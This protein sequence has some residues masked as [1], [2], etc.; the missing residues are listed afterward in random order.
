MSNKNLLKAK[1]IIASVMSAIILLQTNIANASNLINAATPQQPYVNAIADLDK[2]DEAFLR[3]NEGDIHQNSLKAE[4]DASLKKINSSQEKRTLASLKKQG[5]AKYGAM[6]PMYVKAAG[7]KQI[8][9]LENKL[10][11]FLGEYLKEPRILPY[12]QFK[13]AYVQMLHSYAKENSKNSGYENAVPFKTAEDK[14]VNDLLNAFPPEEAYKEYKKDAQEEINWRKKNQ[15]KIEDAAYTV[16]RAAV[17]AIGPE[18]ISLGTAQ[19]LLNLE[20]NGKK[21]ITQSERNSVYAYNLAFLQKQNFKTLSQNGISNAKE[22]KVASVLIK[23]ITESIVIAGYLA[24]K[25]SGPYSKTV[26]DLIIRS[27][28]SIAFSHILGAGFSALLANGNYSALDSLLARYT[29]ME[30]NGPH[31]SDWLSVNHYSQMTQNATGKYLG[32]ISEQAQYN[33]DYSYGNTFADIAQLLSEDASA[34]SSQLLAKYAT[35]RD[36][37]NTIKPFL[38][39][40]LTGKKS[41]V[42]PQQAQAYALK[43]ANT[44]FGDISPTYEYDIDR[45]LLAKYPAIKGSLGQG[46]IVNQER[47]KSKSARTAAFNYINKAATAGD[48]LLM[49]WGTVGLVKMGKNVVGLSKSTYTAIKA[50]KIQNNAKRIAYIRANY[51][52]MGKYISAK[53]SLMRTGNRIKRIFRQPV[54][55]REALKLQNDLNK[56]NLAKLEA[57]AQTAKQKTIQKAAPTQRETAKAQLAQAQYE[58]AQSQQSFVQKA[59]FYSQGYNDKVSSYNTA[60]ESFKNG[61]ANM[62][63]PPVFTT[64]ELEYLQS[65][66][67]Y[68][69]AISALNKA[70]DNFKATSWWN[71]Y[72]AAPLKNWWRK[73][74]SGDG[75]LGLW[76]LETGKG[77][78]IGE[79]LSL[80]SPY[81][82]PTNNYRLFTKSGPSAADKFYAYLDKHNMAF[83][84]KGLRVLNNRAT[85]LGTTLLFNYQVAATTPESLI[86]TGK[87]LPTATELI[88]NAT[89]S[90]DLI[91]LGTIKPFA[92]PTPQP[93]SVFDP[94]I[95]QTFNTIPLPGGNIVNSLSFKAVNQTIKELGL[96][97]ISP[98]VF[99]SIFAKNIYPGIE[100]KI[101]YWTVPAKEQIQKKSFLSIKPTVIAM[102]TWPLVTFGSPS[103]GNLWFENYILRRQNVIETTIN[104][105]TEDLMLKNYQTQ[106][107][108]LL[109]EKIDQSQKEVFQVNGQEMTIPQMIAFIENNGWAQGTNF[110]LK[111]YKQHLSFLQVIA[112]ALSISTFERFLKIIFNEQAIMKI[113]DAN[114]SAKARAAKIND[115]L[116]ALDYFYA[117]Y[118]AIAFNPS[119]LLHI[120]EFVSMKNFSEEKIEKSIN[121]LNE[122]EFAKANIG[123]LFS[124][125]NLR[126]SLRNAL[127]DMNSSQAL[128]I[129]LAIIKTKNTVEQLKLNKD[130]NK[131][132]DVKGCLINANGVWDDVSSIT[133]SRIGVSAEMEYSDIRQAI[134]EW[135]HKSNLPPGEQNINSPKDILEKLGPW[136]SH[137]LGASELTPVHY[138]ETTEGEVHVYNHNYT[139]RMRL[140][141]HEIKNETPHLHL[142]YLTNKN[143]QGIL[144]IPYTFPKEFAKDDIVAALRKLQ[145]YFKPAPAL[146]GSALLDLDSPPEA[147]VLFILGGP[148]GSGK[149]YLYKQLLSNKN[150]PFLNQDIISAEQNLSTLDAGKVLISQMEDMIKREKSFVIE[151]TLS[152]RSATSLIR[153]A[154]ENGYRVMILYTF[155]DSPEE[156]IARVRSRVLE[157]GHDAPYGNLTDRYYKSRNNF[158]NLYKDMADDWIMFYNSD[159]DIIPIASKRQDQSIQILD[160]TLFNATQPQDKL[161]PIAG[162]EAAFQPAPAM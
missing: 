89:K 118:K 26:S 55:A 6:W 162:A 21:V 40:A 59:K 102:T 138:A 71:K 86:T 90:S 104:V 23:N 119:R 150:L 64:G 5:S 32:F 88:F 95:F 76:E 66:K 44:L 133:A 70:T 3:G 58:A 151:S 33:T 120:P 15:A 81:M 117:Y 25:Q 11:Q 20:L 73:P 48:V 35:G 46:A 19:I 17:S 34:Q 146:K 159:T 126:H 49:I 9:A 115:Y 92:V 147:K 28:K 7:S 87:A 65:Y 114:T 84:S 68:N 79:A 99:P 125:Q 27:E 156:S 78:T 62:P 94:K 50:F 83:L 111:T 91:S 139:V 155:V 30:Q 101:N 148:N 160:E 22:K 53:R 96:A 12:E 154:K 63:K 124:S 43:M 112:P 74:A 13:K 67:N 97:S 157:G 132:T 69:S 60:V 72:F 131:F 143:W 107:S 8:N 140:G 75:T 128:N 142:E 149:T 16:A 110:S 41:G 137:M 38:F 158:W 1:K 10:K 144:N 121:F 51:A 36:M 45:A 18:N 116:N 31:W 39:G 141:S 85:L 153:K 123:S 135:I 152:G 42:S 134:V 109:L 80:S 161:S 24:P 14:L 108:P 145:G 29:K 2:I 127:S 54:S 37:E 129:A 4:V 98:L 122:I 56:R 106:V 82:P 57:R 105:D 100:N 93:V 47:K 61:S 113:A 52:K 136:V 103:T 130:S 77:T